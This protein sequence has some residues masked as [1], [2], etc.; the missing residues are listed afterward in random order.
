M[1]SHA[2]DVR[3]EKRRTFAVSAARPSDPA[4][5][6]RSLQRNAG[7][8]AVVSLL[9]ER[10]PRPGG[11]P[12]SLAVQRQLPSPQFIEAEIRYN[13]DASVRGTL[14]TL[15]HR[16]RAARKLLDPDGNAFQDVDSAVKLVCLPPKTPGGPMVFNKP[17]YAAIIA[18]SSASRDDPEAPIGAQPI[19][20][21]DW[22]QLQPVLR[23]AV[24][25]AADCAKAAKEIEAVFGPDVAPAGPT[26]T[27]ETIANRLKGF[28]AQ[29]FVVNYN[30]SSDIT[31]AA[32][33][34]RAGSGII[35]LSGSLIKNITSKTNSAI[36]TLIHEAAHETNAQI[37]DLGYSGSAGFE[38]MT[39]KDKLCNADHYAD[40]AE[41]L[42]GMS[43]YQSHVFL[44]KSGV[45]AGTELRDR[46]IKM[47]K[48]ANSGL[49]ELWSLTLS[50]DDPTML[51]LVPGVDPATGGPLNHKETVQEIEKKR[52]FAA[53]IKNVYGLPSQGRPFVFNDIDHKLVQTA[54]MVFS[55]AINRLKKAGRAKDPAVM[56][57]LAA[58]P[59]AFK[60]GEDAIWKVGGF[61]A[62]RNESA[63]TH[64]RIASLYMDIKKHSAYQT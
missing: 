18:K 17:T 47:A 27:F 6:L 34:A 57:K 39:T 16:L 24:E 3:P 45:L 2:R 59:D 50:M 4:A 49:E 42:L 19:K 9:S 44:P 37:I 61:T 20:A 60:L 15:F 23:K 1:S 62:D 13:G 35:Q 8:A 25:V 41:R 58:Y 31:G 29:N 64:L 32:G 43:R 5:H 46:F 36:S 53:L 14:T 48:N 7:N 11:V 10:L 51:R 33:A 30:S 55:R 38:D 28:S 52:K 63:A 12:P 56:A 54:A 21:D 22:P 26:G 40:V